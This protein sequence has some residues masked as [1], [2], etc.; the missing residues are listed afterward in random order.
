[1]STE[2]V[3]DFFAPH[4]SSVD[5]VVDWLVGSGISPDRIG[6]STNKQVCA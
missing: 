6:Q 2:E 3:I 1:M 4:Q 5:A